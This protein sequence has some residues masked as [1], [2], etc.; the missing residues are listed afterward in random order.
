MIV[1]VGRMLVRHLPWFKEN[2]RK[3][4][5]NHILHDHTLDSTYK[6]VL[7]NLGVFKEDPSS[8]QGAIGIY[9]KLQNYVPVN[10]GKPYPFVVYDD[11]VNC[12]RGNDDQWARANGLNPTERLEGLEPAAQ[13]VHKEMILLQD[14]FDDFY[15]PNSAA[16]RGTLCQVRNMFN[17][18]QVKPDIS[19]NSSCVWELM[20]VMTDS[21][22]CLLAMQ[23]Q[24][25]EKA[26][27]RPDAA[28]AEI[29]QVNFDQVAKALW[30]KSGINKLQIK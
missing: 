14:F 5:V 23:L 9:S 29:E 27:S 6:S 11:G 3:F 17:F 24:D 10:D 7:I 8:T 22:V 2:F 30:V 1:I 20:C 4:S 21:F 13:E 15:R 28:P 19:D 25:M 12:E 16:D 26:C 18:W